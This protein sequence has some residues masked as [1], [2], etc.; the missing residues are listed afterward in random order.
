MV[1]PV[2]LSQCLYR[3]CISLPPEQMDKKEWSIRTYFPHGQNVASHNQKCKQWK[4][5]KCWEHQGMFSSFSSCLLSCLAE[6]VWN[7]FF[8]ESVLDWCLTAEFKHKF[9]LAHTLVSSQELQMCIWTMSC[10]RK[11]SL[12]WQYRGWERMAR[13]C[14]GVGRWCF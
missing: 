13:G 8:S 2:Q 4:W 3:E 9:E 14:S 12:C 6:G 10:L 11:K 5:Q 7:D 1:G